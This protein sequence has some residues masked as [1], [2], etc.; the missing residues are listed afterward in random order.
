MHYTGDWI[1]LE[2]DLDGTGNLTSTGIRFPDRPAL[3]ESVYRL[4]SSD[5][6]VVA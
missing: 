1:G 3:S 5:R 2:A 6:H 4:R